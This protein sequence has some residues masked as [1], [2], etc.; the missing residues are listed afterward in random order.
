MEQI[1][2]KLL[3]S[4]KQEINTDKNRQLIIHDIINICDTYDIFKEYSKL[5]E[6][7][8]IEENIAINELFGTIK[9]DNNLD[10]YDLS[11]IAIDGIEYN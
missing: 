7:E 10:K 4:I 6:Q 9:N 1:T 11:S 5:L 8:I 3:E 2:N